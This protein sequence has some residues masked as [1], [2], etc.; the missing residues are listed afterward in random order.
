[1]WPLIVGPPSGWQLTLRRADEWRATLPSMHNLFLAFSFLTA[2][3]LEMGE[4]HNI[5]IDI[6]PCLIGPA[7]WMLVFEFMP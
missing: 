6:S 4:L 2:L 5:H 1:M 7:L 3:I